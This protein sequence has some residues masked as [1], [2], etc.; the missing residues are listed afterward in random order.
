MNEGTAL[1]SEAPASGETSVQLLVIGGNEKLGTRLQE[2][3]GELPTRVLRV[4]ATEWRSPA[5]QEKRTPGPCLAVIALEEEGEAATEEILECTQLVS[6]TFRPQR[7]VVV[8]RGFQL[9]RVLN[10]LRAGADGLQPHGASALQVAEELRGK[11]VKREYY[12]PDPN[13]WLQSLARAAGE[14]N[15]GLETGIQLKKLL[16]I[17]VSQ[18]GVDRGSIMLVEGDQ[19]R[20]AA[21]V[22]FPG[23]VEID[24]LTAIRPGSITEWV[25]EHR[26]ARLV[27]GDQPGS[28]PL[29]SKVES[30]V[31]APIV[32]E[33]EV[34]GTV[35]FSS[36]SRRRELSPSDLSTAE[37]FASLL[38]MAIFNRR[39][40]DQLVDNERLAAIGSTMSGVSHCIKNLL[41]VF[42]GSSMI[43][44]RALE[45]QDLG[46]AAAGFR[47]MNNGVRRIENLVLDM[48]DL[49]K[50]REPEPEPVD[51]VAFKE[52]LDEIMEVS[53][54]R[55]KHHFESTLL[56]EGT[57]LLDRYRL[58]RAVLN[59]LSNAV[60][61]IREGGEVRMMIRREGDTLVIAVSDNG[62]GVPESDLP[63][64]FQSF[65][66]TKGSTGTGLGLAMVHKFCEE[67]NGSVEADHDPK[68]GGLRVTIRVPLAE[69]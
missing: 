16:R 59:L 31:C 12:F 23:D 8:L 33:D 39:L 22:G 27:I 37:V 38:A 28:K 41:T 58:Q 51:I 57:Y 30:A 46:Q 63:T 47:I 1:K 44:E 4:P 5:W 64:I 11:G 32:M 60:D 65:Y 24:S 10:L 26:N 53:N 69:G 25:L 9:D 7:L 34:L 48:L 20:L 50:K 21:A 29:S 61:A 15:L 2:Y 68:L 66:S 6:V 36:S 17:F 40:M 3:L 49:T 55:K 62:P 35:N 56:M 45:Q 13:R 52:E 14:I 54:A 43:M 19:M 42:K 18:I 67:N